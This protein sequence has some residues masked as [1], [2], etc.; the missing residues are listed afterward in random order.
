MT[1]PEDF[2]WAFMQMWFFWY[3]IHHRCRKNSATRMK[4]YRLHPEMTHRREQTHGVYTLCTNWEGE[5]F[6]TGKSCSNDRLEFKQTSFRFLKINID[7]RTL[8]QVGQPVVIAE[9]LRTSKS[10]I[11]LHMCIIIVMIVFNSH[12]QT[13]LWAWNVLENDRNFHLWK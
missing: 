7:R 5:F 9:V 13:D 12:L 4:M 11:S 6:I 3:E 8:R 10:F 1:R 2:F